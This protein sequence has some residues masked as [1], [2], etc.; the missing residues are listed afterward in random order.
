MGDAALFG[1]S[2]KEI[3]V[4]SLQR[5]MAAGEAFELIDIRTQAEVAR[6][7]IPHS[8]F[9]PMHLIPLHAQT[10]A[11]RDK[12]VILY[13]R[14]GARSA[15]ACAFLMQQGIDNVINLSGGIVSWAQNGLPIGEFHAE[16][17]SLV[18]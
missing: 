4:S 2:I 10:I 13:C 1:Y 16:E 8:K 18:G 11:S 14:T 3:D 5:R 7:I 12:P 9:L 6:G 17:A 15:Q